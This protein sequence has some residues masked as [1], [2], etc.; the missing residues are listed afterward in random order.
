MIG[1]SV[2]FGLGKDWNP[3]SPANQN[4][5]HA[6]GMRSFLIAQLISFNLSPGGLQ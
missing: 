6:E 5:R 2:F 3:C 1:A 4:A